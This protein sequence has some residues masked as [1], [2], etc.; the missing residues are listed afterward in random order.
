[1]DE[2]LIIEIKEGNME[3]FRSLIEKYKHR[4]FSLSIGI[5]KNHEMAEEALQDSFLK[6]FIKINSFKGRSKFSTWLFSIVINESLKRFNKKRF[7]LTDILEL[8]DESEHSTFNE[9]FKNIEHHERKHVINEILLQLSA[10]ECSLL[11]LYYLEELSIKDIQSITKLG[12]SD[13]KTSL[14][15]ARIHFAKLAEL[16]KN[17]MVK[18]YVS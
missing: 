13:I 3:S 2:P 12:S 6:A 9:Y 1:M 17:K 10:K 5:T 11:K 8:Q 7:E 15:R 16:R 14:H 18:D 4:A